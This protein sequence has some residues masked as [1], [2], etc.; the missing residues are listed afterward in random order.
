MRQGGAR[1]AGYPRGM[2]ARVAYPG[3]Y[4]LAGFRG[5]SILRAWYPRAVP[6]S[7]VHSVSHLAAAT[8]ARTVTLCSQDTV[9]RAAASLLQDYE[10]LQLTAVPPAAQASGGNRHFAAWS[11]FSLCY[12]ENE[13]PRGCRI[14][15]SCIV[16][17][18]VS[19]MRHSSTSGPRA[20]IRSPL[21]W[22]VAPTP[23]MLIH[24]LG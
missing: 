13:G 10:G 17:I 22:Q 24:R 9:A 5:G 21:S 4:A 8:A 19:C 16:S 1:E 11:G 23:S 15:T 14:G 3:P 18:C 2:R 7:L 20:C 12:A 6:S